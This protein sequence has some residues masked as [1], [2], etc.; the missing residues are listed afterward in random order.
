[1][2]NW[3]TEMQVPL[4]LQRVLASYGWVTPMDLVLK[5]NLVDPADASLSLSFADRGVFVF[6]CHR[7]RSSMQNEACLVL[8]M[9]FRRLA[10]LGHRKKSYFKKEAFDANRT[11]SKQSSVIED[12]RSALAEDTIAEQRILGEV[13]ACLESLVDDVVAAI[14]LGRKEYEDGIR[15]QEIPVRT[16]NR[17]KTIQAVCMLQSMA[18]QNP[19]AT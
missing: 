10:R 19:N 3:L 13:F 8:Q 17:Q 4:S 5:K 18:L 2:A 11:F 6:E 9:F 1:M 15:C 12:L 7:A 14:R 16:E